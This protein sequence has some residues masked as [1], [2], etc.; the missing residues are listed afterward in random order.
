M[1]KINKRFMVVYIQFLI[2]AL[3]V[4]MVLA[5]FDAEGNMKPLG[6]AGGAVFWLGILGGVVSYIIFFR[7][8]FHRPNVLKFF[9][10][11]PAMTADAVLIISLVVTI[12]LEN[13]NYANKIVA[14]MFVFLLILSLYSHFLLNGKIF[15]KILIENR[16]KK[17]RQQE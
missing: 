3:S 7:K 15:T 6:Y 1:R 17:G 12:F 8:K 10:N 4:W 9:S 14:V 13:R 2:S 5:A 11:K 16:K